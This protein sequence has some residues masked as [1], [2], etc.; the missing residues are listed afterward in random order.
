[1]NRW[2]AFKPKAT[3][4]YSALAWNRA[5]FKSLCAA[6]LSYVGANTLNTL[7]NESHYEITHSGY[8]ALIG[9]IMLITFIAAIYPSYQ[10]L[11]KVREIEK[12]LDYRKMRLECISKTQSAVWKN[13]LRNKHT[14]IKP[15]DYV[16]SS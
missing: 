2:H 16:V 8:A 7:F 10:D 6:L 4:G 3:T 9:P 5:L 13:S 1:M 12:E 11:K 15:E 14:P